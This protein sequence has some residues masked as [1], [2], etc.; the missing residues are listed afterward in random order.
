VADPASGISIFPHA[1]RAT[2]NHPVPVIKGSR[3]WAGGPTP[4]GLRL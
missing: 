4:S 2:K 1:L 3:T